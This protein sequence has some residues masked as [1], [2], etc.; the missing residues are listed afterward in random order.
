MSSLIISI[1]FQISYIDSKRNY[2]ILQIAM[3]FTCLPVEYAENVATRADSW[4]ILFVEDEVGSKNDKL[5]NS[6]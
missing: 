6:F 2:I 1:S 5:K 4:R 3:E